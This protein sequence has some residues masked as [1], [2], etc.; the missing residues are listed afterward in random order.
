MGISVVIPSYNDG[1]RLPRTI[2]PLLADPATDELIIVIDGSDDGSFEALQ[3]RARKD[4]RVR[5]FFIENRGR[6]AAC[7]FGIEQ[8]R[9]DVV[10]LIDADVVAA[11]DFLVTGHAR[12]HEDAV[13]R[14]VV[15]YMPLTASRRCPGSFVREH[16]SRMYELR[17]A[18]FERNPSVI[19]TG[20]W[21]GNMSLPRSALEAAGGFDANLGLRYND[22][23]ELGLRL[24]GT[25]L[26]PVFDRRL[27]AEHDFERSVRVYLSTARKYG[28]DLARIEARHPG[29]VVMPHPPRSR[30]DAA[31]RRL[32]AR[33]RIHR[34]LL[35]VGTRCVEVMGFLGIYKV[36]GQVGHKLE[37]LQIEMGMLDARRAIRSSGSP[38][39][40]CGPVGDL[41]S[42]RPRRVTRA[43][44]A[45][46]SRRTP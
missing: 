46:A 27:L 9:S 12:W 31:V 4:L 30:L 42:I 29:K 24:A 35:S 8:A 21:A 23:L 40:D 13:A 10:L 11:N 33:R 17:A 26:E 18:E 38:K 45:R 2:A 14:L 22:D 34:V 15:G 20:L 25:G 36:E 41:G 3:A 37:R 44:R 43:A 16:Y 1:P 32:V 5:P 19:L 39:W 6:P 7:Q 28:E